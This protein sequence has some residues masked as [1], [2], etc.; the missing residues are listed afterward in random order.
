MGHKAD[1]DN[2]KVVGLI[3]RRLDALIALSLNPPDKIT[4]YG[5]AARLKAMGFTNSEIALILG[6]TKTHIRKE[7]SVGKKV[8]AHGRK[9]NRTKA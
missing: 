4:I 5:Q 9:G 8:K 1:M 6:K 3:L 2:D 7:L